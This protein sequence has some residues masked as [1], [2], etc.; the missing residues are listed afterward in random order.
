MSPNE[1]RVRA[2]SVRLARVAVAADDVIQEL[3][4]ETLVKEHVWLL[5]TPAEHLRIAVDTLE[6]TMHQ[7]EQHWQAPWPPETTE[8]DRPAA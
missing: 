3:A 7:L 8:P 2:L 1:D 6:E 4:V 5:A